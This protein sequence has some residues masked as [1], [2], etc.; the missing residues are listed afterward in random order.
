MILK[1]KKLNSTGL[2]PTKGTINSAGIDLYSP[3]LVDCQPR[4]ITKVPLG[5]SVEI[6]EGYFGLI[7]DRSSIG[8]K[9]VIVTAGV[10]DSDYRGELIICF[11]NCGA[12]EHWFRAG[13]KIAQMLILPVPT[14][15]IEGVEELS[16][17]QRGAGG[18]GST[19][20]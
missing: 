2:T 14:M 18:F 9:G 12:G 13:D 15:D 7:R 3:I 20:R 1:V 5:I 17:T 6:P 10:I 16:L 8:S 11:M 4:F 19:G